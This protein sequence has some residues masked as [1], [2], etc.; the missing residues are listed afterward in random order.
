MQA[1][2]TKQNRAAVTLLHGPDDRLFWGAKTEHGIL[3][4]STHEQ[5]RK[6]LDFVFGK[7]CWFFSDRRLG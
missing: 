4:V 5:L 1:T 7:G 6:R 3:R 2:R